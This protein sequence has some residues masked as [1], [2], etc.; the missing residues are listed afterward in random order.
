[1][2]EYMMTKKSDLYSRFEQK[3]WTCSL[4]R[5]MQVKH[6]CCSL[7]L[8]W[9]PL[10][11]T[12][13]IDLY[14]SFEFNWAVYRS[15]K[16]SQRSITFQWFCWIVFSLIVIYQASP[17]LLWMPL[18]FTGFLSRIESLWA[19][20]SFTGHSCKLLPCTLVLDP[21]QTQ[22]FCVLPNAGYQS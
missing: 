3:R 2:D 9:P 7:Y 17:V 1:M 20:L 12:G 19:P 5:F 11:Q 10:T 13:T 14:S 15:D 8:H 16:L 4:L 21:S 22:S 18:N 6:L